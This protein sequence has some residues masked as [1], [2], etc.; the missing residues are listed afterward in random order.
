M[1]DWTNWRKQYQRAV[2]FSSL[3]G[4][5]KSSCCAR[6]CLAKAGPRV[7]VCACSALPAARLGR[8]AQTLPFTARVTP[9]HPANPQ[10]LIPPSKHQL[11]R[12]GGLLRAG[13]APHS[14]APSQASPFLSWWGTGQRRFFASPHTFETRPSWPLQC[15]L[16]TRHPLLVKLCA[17]SGC[18]IGVCVQNHMYF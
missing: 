7:P 8:E 9:L 5:V 11:R 1:S 17:S 2:G 4:E 12:G 6:L 13:Q 3:D 14:S 16:L 18:A 10:C 15:S